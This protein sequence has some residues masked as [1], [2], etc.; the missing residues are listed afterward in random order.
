MMPLGRIIPGSVATQ[1]VERTAQYMV[2]QCINLG[3]IPGSSTLYLPI[4]DTLK[5]EL[6]ATCFVSA[7]NLSQLD[8]GTLSGPTG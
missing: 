3:I 5:A 2:I 4:L 1:D 7:L 6:K 8:D